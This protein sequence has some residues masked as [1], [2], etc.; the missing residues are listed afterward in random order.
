MFERE[1]IKNLIAWKSDKKRKTPIA[2]FNNYRLYTD[3][4]SIRKPPC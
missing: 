3:V 2:S 1:I 4:K